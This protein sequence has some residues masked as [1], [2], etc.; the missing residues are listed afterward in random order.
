MHIL[1]VLDHPFPPD[2]RVENEARSLVEAGFAVTVLAIAP[3]DRP[4]VETVE[5]V[6]VIRDRLPKTVRNKL[7]GLAGTLPLLSWY[8][9]RRIRKLHAT[10]RF[11]ALHLHDLYLF[12]GGLRAGRRLGLPVVGDLHENW[13]EALRHYAWSTRFPGNVVVNLRRWERLEKE[14]VQAVDRL[15]VVVEEAAERNVALGVPPER[16]TVV[17]NTIKLDVFDRYEPEPDLI[18]SLRSPLTL[19]YTGGFDV[20]RGLASAI[21]A[22]PAVLEQVPGARLVLVG[23]GRI[24]AEL[25]ALARRLGVASAVRFE[26]WQPQPRLKSYILGSDICLIPH[27]RTPHTDAT[28]PHKLFH[29]MYFGRPVVAGDCRPL[30]RILGE[31]GAGL[32]YPAGDAAALARAVMTLAASP[33]QAAEMG[34]R[35]RE[36]VLQTYHWDATVQ[37]LVDL[38]AA[39]ARN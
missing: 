17:P 39:L 11:D 33:V 18:A 30:A 12:G 14:W 3:D 6:R 26:G 28:I 31:T 9:A 21:E 38:Y 22:M 1:M 19:T 5:G 16:I 24:R 34:R 15:V 8:V 2:V 23:D 36:A 7:R 32:V 4:P 29:Y 25:E 37:G 27:L 20:H 13:V 10:Y 35:G